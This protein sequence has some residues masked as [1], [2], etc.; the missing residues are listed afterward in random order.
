M[1]S[2]APGNGQPPA[3][4]ALGRS[5]AATALVLLLLLWLK[6]LPALIGALAGFAVFRLVWGCEQRRTRAEQLSASLL[7]LLLLAGAALAVFEA[8]EL[9]LSASSDGLPKLLQLM[10]DT[11]DRIR[12]TAPD[13]I[14]RRLPDSAAALQEALSGWLRAHAGQM[15][16]LGRDALRVTLHLVIGLV[17][18]MLA[19][20]S[21]RR[22]P[23]AD[24]SR[25]A[26]DRWR[27]LVLAFAD[28]LAVQLRI[29]LVN[30]ALTALYLVGILPL[31]GYH[32]PL[33]LTLVAST[34]FASLLPIVGNL[35]SN[36]AIVLAAL[37]VSPW[38]GVASLVFLLAI[39]KLEYFLNAHFVGSRVSMPP[40]ALL[41]SMLVLESA[42]GAAGLIAAPIYCAWLTRE[43]RE[44]GWI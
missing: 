38:L 23:R 32:V 27:Q 15:Q 14:V 44:G 7:A 36:T 28:I 41:V 2:C 33:A 1:D 9:L 13:W 4:A 19:G 18:G 43:L 22:Q 20:H 40:Y 39:H 8:Y 11:L 16:K 5:V 10:A 37:T 6:L 25:L 31:L 26:Q 42:F 34:F 29:A 3:T 35:F 17:I 21:M 24:L 12:T 30:A